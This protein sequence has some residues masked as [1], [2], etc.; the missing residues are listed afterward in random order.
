MGFLGL[1]RGKVPVGLD[2]GGNTFRLAQLKQSADKPVLCNYASFKA[3][4]DLVHEGEVVDIDG[5]AKALTEFWRGQ[6]I[7][8]K[9]VVV[10]IANQKVIMRVI[11]MPYMTE[12]ELRSAIQFQIGEYIPI[13]IEEAIIDF[14]I[15]SHHENEQ[16]E[17]TM[18]VLVVAA[19]RE[20]V[21]N[22]VKALE[23]AKLKPVVVDISS[24][25]FARAVTDNS[26]KPF[27]DDDEEL[28]GATALINIG[29]NLTDIVVVEDD[30]PRFARI[31]NIGGSVFTGALVDQLGISFDE[32]DD[33]KFRIGLPSLDEEE[34]QI[35]VGQDISHYVDIVQNIL[36]QEM[37][38]F[39]AEIRRSLDYYLVQAT[40]AKSIDKIIVS[41]SGAKLKNFLPHL[42]ES[43]RLEIKLGQPLNNVLVCKRLQKMGLGEEEFS[44]ATCLG[45]AMRGIEQ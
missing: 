35:D 7:S 2:I 20:M 23:K 10:G 19:R 9:R 44:L 28:A 4:R 31:G 36:E 14:Q 42:K 43:L 33:L 16:Q 3:P 24:L 11:E 12:A 25:A 39:I 41:G 27:I 17:K 22:T 29:S 38:K 13:P 26:L 34:E 1:S 40:K 30:I 5:V 45:L 8:E 21:E 6:K 32:A 15:I 18:D 37:F